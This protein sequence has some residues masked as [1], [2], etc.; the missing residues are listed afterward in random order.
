VREVKEKQR[1]EQQDRKS[2]KAAE[3]QTEKI[4]PA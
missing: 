3:V 2:Q 1:R 4:N